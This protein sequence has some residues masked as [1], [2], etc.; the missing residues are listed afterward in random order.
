MGVK[1]GAEFKDLILEK[2]GTLLYISNKLVAHE[3]SCLGVP[4][5]GRGC[6]SH[7]PKFVSELNCPDSE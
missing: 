4:L 7:F 3:P 2:E 5:W 1:D 6:C